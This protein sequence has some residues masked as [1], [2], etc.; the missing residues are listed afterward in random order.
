VRSRDTRKDSAHD[1]NVERLAQLTMPGGSGE[2]RQLRLLDGS[3]ERDWE[4]IVEAEHWVAW[5]PEGQIVREGKVQW[6]VARLGRNEVA[7]W[8]L[9]EMPLEWDGLGSLWSLQEGDGP[10]EAVFLDAGLLELQTGSGRRVSWASRWR[11][12]VCPALPLLGRGSESEWRG[13]L[14]RWGRMASWMHGKQLLAAWG[15]DNGEFVG[16]ALASAGASGVGVSLEL[17]AWE[18]VEW[19]LRTASVGREL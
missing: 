11:S 19:V 17:A 3:L 12:D 9:V 14:Q 1:V 18:R 10:A 13:T 6:S 8:G 4:R 5:C 15:T 16:W 7:G 2:T